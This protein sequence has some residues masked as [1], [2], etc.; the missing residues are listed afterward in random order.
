MTA[1]QRSRLRLLSVLGLVD[2][3]V[4]QCSSASGNVRDPAPCSQKHS[5]VSHEMRQ[6]GIPSDESLQQGRQPV[7]GAEPFTQQATSGSH[8]HGTPSSLLRFPLQLCAGN[9]MS[10]QQ[11]HVHEGFQKRCQLSQGLRRCSRAQRHLHSLLA[12][13]HSQLQYTGGTG[14]PC[15]IQPTFP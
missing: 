6:K 2:V 11:L 14:P 5:T 7:T 13:L 8:G 4:H 9:Q 10:S 1:P 3:F 12:A 15:L